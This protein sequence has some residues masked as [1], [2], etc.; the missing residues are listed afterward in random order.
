MN[1]RRW[2]D[3]VVLVAG[4][5]LIFAPFWMASY[6]V[7]GSA[8]LNSVAVGVLLV[9]TSWIAL[10]RPK[11]WEEWVNAT[12]GG[13]LVVAPFALG[14]P[15]AGPV[16]LNHIVIGLIVVADAMVALARSRGELGEA[17]HR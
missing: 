16:T 1:T 17:Q 7:A 5:W 9:A 2:Q 4:L 8:A 10:A 15:D 3:W 12:L 6:A 11:P 13:W 14:F